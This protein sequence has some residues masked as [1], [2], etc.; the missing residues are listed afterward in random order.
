MI[1]ATDT[2]SMLRGAFIVAIS[3]LIGVGDGSVLAADTFVTAVVGRARLD[4]HPL[5]AHRLVG[6]GSSDIEIETDAGGSCAVLHGESI[7]VQLCGDTKVRIPAVEGDAPQMIEISRGEIRLTSMRQRSDRRLKIRT[8]ASV[9]RPFTT[10][11]HISVEPTSGKTVVTSL[12]SRAV[13]VSTNADEKRSAILNTGQQIT[14]ETGH[15]PGKIQKLDGE[16]EQSDSPCFSGEVFRSE[17][18]AQDALKDG[19]AALDRFAAADIP[20]SSLPALANPFP[21][22]EG[23]VWGLTDSQYFESGCNPVSCEPFVLPPP[24]GLAEPPPCT[25]LP[26]EHCQRP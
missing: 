13:V 2:R 6:D 12:E 18:V 17:A 9:V 16:A 25:G 23:F 5:T 11:L 4:G 21:A 26:G 1:A 15:P 8:P 20:D 14:I 7:L 22:P 24:P 19:Q 3:L 10:V